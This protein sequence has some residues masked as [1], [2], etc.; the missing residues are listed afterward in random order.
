MKPRVTPD[1]VSSRARRLIGLGEEAAR[2]FRERFVGRTLDVLAESRGD[3]GNSCTGFSSNYIK[4]KVL[5]PSQGSLNEILPVL[6]TEAGG[7]AGIA[8][9]RLAEGRK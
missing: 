9:G 3:N 7:P 1:V 5:D 2:R 8:T 6:I 4:I